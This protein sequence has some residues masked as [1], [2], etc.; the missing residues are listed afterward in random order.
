M[1]AYQSHESKDAKL[2]FAVDL[3][4]ISC[5]EDWQSLCCVVAL[6]ECGFLEEVAVKLDNTF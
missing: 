5:A 3:S 2:A 4:V 1:A 6:A